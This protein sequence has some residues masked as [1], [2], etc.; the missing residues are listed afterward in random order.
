MQLNNSIY[1]HIY[2]AMQICL[3]KP[4]RIMENGYNFNNLNFGKINILLRWSPFYT[5]DYESLD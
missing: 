3:N 1:A 4:L 2:A 5:W